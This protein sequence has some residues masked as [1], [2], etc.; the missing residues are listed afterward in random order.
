[1]VEENWGEPLKQLVGG[2]RRTDFLSTGGVWSKE[3]AGSCET[4]NIAALVSS[5]PLVAAES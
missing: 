2:P 3:R 1:M 4:R 5:R